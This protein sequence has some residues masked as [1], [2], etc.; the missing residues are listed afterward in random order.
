MTSPVIRSLACCLVGIAAVAIAADPPKVER[1]VPWAT[2]KVV[3][4]PEPPPAYRLVNA[5]P[6]VKLIHPLAVVF[7]PGSDR[8]FVAEQGGKIVSFRNQPD[9]RPDLF[10]DLPNELKRL[11]EHPGAKEFD[12][13]FGLV[14]HPRFAENRYCYV[15]Y[16][17]RGK[18][19]KTGP[20]D[21]EKNLPDGSRI[22]RFTVTATDPPRA[23]PS[24]EEILLTF[25]Q[26]GHNGCDLHFGPD[27]MLYI[28]TGDATDPSPPDLFRTGQDITD[29]LS[30]ILRIDVDRKDPG[31]NYAIPKDN[32]F[33]G[34]TQF[35]KPVREEVWAYGFRNPW[36]MS[37]DRQT[38]DLWAGDVGW[39]LWEMVHKI[40]KGGNYGWSV[41][42]AR[43]PIN[44]TWPVG[45][46]PIRPPVIE[47][48]HTDGASVTG[49]FVYRGSRFPELQ[50]AYIFAD[51]MTRRVWAARI[52][53]TRLV[54]MTDLVRPTVRVVA[55]GQDHAGELY[56]AD[57]DAG[58]IHKFERNDAAKTTTAFP[59]TLSAT[60]LFADVSTHTPAPGVYP[61][62]INAKQWQ[63]H[64]TSEHL[65]ALPGTAAVIDHGE[66]KPLGGQIDWLP[67]RYHFPENGVLVKTLS[68]ETDRGNPASRRRVET[69]L[70]HF[71]GLFWNAYTYAWRDD[72]SDADLVPADGAEK[73]FKVSDPITG[74]GE[75]AWQFHSRS[76]CLTCHN[77]WAETTL[78]FNPHQLHRP[79]GEGNQLVRLGELGLLTRVDKGGRPKPVY[80]SA[81]LAKEKRLAD[82]HDSTAS[83]ANRAKAYLHAN[84]GHCHRNGGGGSVDFELH[85]FA[86]FN[87][88]ALKNAPPSRGHF[89]LPDAKRIAPGDPLRS[90]VLYRMSKFGTGRMPQLGTELVDEAGVRL[91]RD[92]LSSL[93]S[94]VP[95]EPPAV[96]LTKCDD[97]ELSNRLGSV[98][99]AFDLVRAAACADCPPDARR[100]VFAIASKLPPGP[101]RDLFDGYLPRTGDRKLGANPRPQTVLS[102]TGDPARGKDLFWSNR[103]TCQTC[104]RIDGK[105]VEIGPDLSVIGKQRSPTELLESILEPSR[106]VEPQYQAYMLRTADGRSVTGLL[107]K[108]DTTEV[109]V[110]DAQNNAVKVSAA[111]VESLTPARDSLMPAGAL[112]DLTPQEAADLLAYLTSRK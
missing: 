64:A 48:S 83:L 67:Y 82:P 71:D 14:F 17:M 112:A 45:P 38:G 75:Q 16:A 61:F 8:F 100:R 103:L 52:D 111:D 69:Q 46:T 80:T 41:T 49:G 34:Q 12:T 79:T 89:D 105:G 97:P 98:A 73:V 74:S 50:G 32:P 58:T 55:F 93:K 57:Y 5:F 26:G 11:H 40:E 51:Y 106:R 23:D 20:F 28:S 81:E 27:G 47:I 88:K 13:C 65:I 102:R 85:A 68:L 96:D 91:V 33:V 62:A 1:R 66:R 9:A 24:S 92:W 107:V 109:V 63:D 43:Q 25:P 44:S 87:S 22:S 18:K 39:E 42:E 78:A 29:L 21:H 56:V 54:S 110:R 84:C 30:S 104:H 99:T 15:C 76:Q 101:V 7:A 37:F 60:G 72:Q 108:R 19:G 36:R 95:A 31:K 6:N 35:G 53:G 2:S 94:G 4:S 10:I 77:P 3:G 90:V 59:R 70:L 86:D